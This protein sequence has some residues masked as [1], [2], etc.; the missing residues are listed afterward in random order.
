M[1]IP[2]DGD[3][4]NLDHVVKIMASTIIEENSF[5]KTIEAQVV[6]SI[7]LVTIWFGSCPADD[8]FKRAQLDATETEIMSKIEKLI[9][10]HDV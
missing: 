8:H 4:L 10:Y 2:A 6:G 3:L 7:D 5:Q 9:D 1:W